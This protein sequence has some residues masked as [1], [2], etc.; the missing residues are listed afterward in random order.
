MGR[1]SP[2]THP[3][4]GLLL[5]SILREL[6]NSMPRIEPAVVAARSQFGELLPNRQGQSRAPVLPVYW[7][8]YS[9]ARRGISVRCLVIYKRSQSAVYLVQSDVSIE[10]P[11]NHR[12]VRPKKSRSP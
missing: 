8:A 9:F 4:T 6:P 5:D 2:A 11:Q 12:L 10:M 7:A 3:F 1:A